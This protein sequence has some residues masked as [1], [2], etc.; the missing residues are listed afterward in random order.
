MDVGFVAG[1]ATLVIGGMWFARSWS[2]R[3]LPRGSGTVPIDA[4]HALR[5]WLQGGDDGALLG[6]LLDLQEIGALRREEGEWIR[7]PADSAPT[8]LG[9][10]LLPLLPHR[11]TTAQVTVLAQTPAISAAV[12]AL[13][14]RWESLGYAPAYEHRRRAWGLAWFLGLAIAASG[15]WH[16]AEGFAAQSGDVGF[17][18]L[19]GLF[20]VAATALVVPLPRLTPSGDQLRERLGRPAVPE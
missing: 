14:A 17:T 12:Q 6:A 2:R 11:C 1:Y 4:D 9:G 13:A 19:M 16:A 5:G 18:I 15:G 10:A 20:G 3:D 8:G 7:Q